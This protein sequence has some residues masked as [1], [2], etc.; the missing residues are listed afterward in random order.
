MPKIITKLRKTN[1]L[2]PSGL[3]CLAN[4]PTVN[5][6]AGCVHNCLYC[7]T[8]GYSVYPGD[9]SIEIYENMAE[10]I[11][12]EIKRKR[13]KPAAV[14]FCPSCDPFQPVSQ[15][16][17]I[18]FDVM[19]TLLKND[20]GVQFVTKG[21]IS[22]E[23]FELFEEHNSK[24]AGQVGLTTMDDKILSVIEPVAAKAKDRID[25]LERLIEIGVKASVRCDPL[26]HNVTDIDKQLDDLFS[27]IA[28]AGCR[29]AA[30]SYLFLRPAII[31]SFKK[32]I[33]NVDALD[34]ILKPFS[35]GVNLS[36]GLKNSM[37]K[38]LP[39]EVR[40]SSFERIRGIAN[41]HGIKIHICGCK[42][43]DITNESCYITREPENFQDRLFLD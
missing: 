5:I 4:L 1:F 25:Q 42:N 22:D 15:I 23:I 28:E 29:D 20:I 31:S 14:Y 36:I 18:V 43:H 3:R 7:Y 19:K 10:R 2:T 6:S 11:A 24:V 21:V 37:G 16:Q 32:N 34:E 17:Q 41:N 40:K 27:A 9:G 8:K 33:T 26:I 30:V 38:M 35:Q 12:D 13:K 39:L